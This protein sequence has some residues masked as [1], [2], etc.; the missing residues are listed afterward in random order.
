MKPMKNLV[1]HPAAVDYLKTKKLFD[2]KFEAKI[3]NEMPLPADV[4]SKATILVNP[5]AYTK[6]VQLIMGF[7]SEV[8]WHGLIHRDDTDPS[9]FHLE[10]IL[11]Y[12]QTVTGTNITADQNREYEWLMSLGA[13]K[14]KKL[15][16]HGH[17]HVNMGVFSSGTDDDLQ[18]DLVNMLNQPDDFYLF[19]IMNKRLEIFVRLYD[20]KFG[21]MFETKDVTIHIT[22]GVLDLSKF[23]EDARAEVKP[24][25]YTPP[26]AGTNQHNKYNGGNS[27]ANTP[28]KNLPSAPSK[29]VSSKQTGKNKN[30]T[31]PTGVNKLDP[32]DLEDSDDSYEGDYPFGYFNGDEWIPCRGGW[33]E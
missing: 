13:E 33:D 9:V 29:G 25:V 5:V 11:V 14:C 8:G 2:G 26:V 15:R 20:N 22:D 19:F 28:S 31:P 30:T 12:P 21:V 23:M 27:V 7:A 6:M 3:F 24:A 10:D 17:S 32:P 16:F 4:P 1:L 18:R